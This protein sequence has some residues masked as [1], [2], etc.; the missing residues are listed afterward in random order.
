M[1]YERGLEVRQDSR[2]AL[3]WYR[4]AAKQGNALAAFHIGSLYERG[5]GVNRDYDRAAKWYGQAAAAGSDAAQAALAYL[6]ERGLGVDRS[7]AR[8]EARYDVSATNWR[9]REHF[10]AEAT[11][12]LGRKG[13]ALFEPVKPDQTNAA[14][15]L[16]VSSQVEV[17]FAAL[18]EVPTLA[19]APE[20][21][22]GPEPIAGN[23]ENFPLSKIR[24]QAPPEAGPRPAQTADSGPV[25]SALPS[26]DMPPSQQILVGAAPVGNRADEA[27]F[28]ELTA[29]QNLTPEPKLVAGQPRIDAF[30][31]N[32][33][34]ASSY[35]VLE[36]AWR[37]LSLR[38]AQLLAGL[39]PAVKRIKQENGVVLRLD[40]G[41]L[42]SQSAAAAICVELRL[43]GQYCEP[44]DW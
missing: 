19:N 18:D 38:H 35:K 2:L 4:R 31:V 5:V 40:A 44:V 39:D 32:V 29:F 13:P 14:Q 22:D 20:P 9:K 27:L 23:G 25:L 7:F 21:A 26:V 1:M 37:G 17:N 30:A 12:A 3:R 28:Q 41:P 42:N 16:P 43:Q 11:F 8:A 24:S 33:A 15:P 6:Y 36:R 34:T 10:P